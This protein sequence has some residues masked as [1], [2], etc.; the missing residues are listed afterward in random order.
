[1]LSPP[2]ANLLDTEPDE[3][4][5]LVISV[6]GSYPYMM[7]QPDNLPPFVHPIACG[8]HF[9]GRESIPMLTDGSAKPFNPLKPRAA[10]I[11]IAHAFASR[12]ANTEEF[13]WRTIASEER[14]IQET[15]SFNRT[16][17]RGESLA[18]MQAMIIYT[19]M[20]LTS[21][22]RDH[23]MENRS[24]FK[25]MNELGDRLKGFFPAQF[26]PCHARDRPPTWHQWIS[27]ETRWRITLVC[28]L[29]ARAL[30]DQ[31]DQGFPRPDGNPIPS[32][33]VLWSTQ[34]DQDVANAEAVSPTPPF[35]AIGDLAMAL[36]GSQTGVSAA[37]SL[38]ARNDAL[39]KWYAALDGLGM[40]VTAVMARD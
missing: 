31:A 30:G 9:D 13:L 14:H 11:G 35:T 1:M 21:L 8:L 38:E 17:F 19:I 10:C 12:T 24:P 2:E 34:G 7:T 25:V 18:A 16:T 40:V 32:T 22:G 4:R 26:T 27:E 36:K 39:A 23:L 33:N 29:V 28:W 15:V 37:M 20:R 3:C 6:I 5:R